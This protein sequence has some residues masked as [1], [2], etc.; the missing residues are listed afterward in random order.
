MFMTLLPHMFM[1]LFFAAVHVRDFVFCCRTCIPHM[2]SSWNLSSCN[3][4]RCVLSSWPS[5]SKNKSCSKNKLSWFEQFHFLCRAV[6][7]FKKVSSK[8]LSSYRNSK[9]WPFPHKN[10]QKNH[11]YFL[12]H[13][14]NPPASGASEQSELA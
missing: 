14:F 4:S 13:F 6:D 9:S 3:L 7:F 2:S 10:I 12:P 1:T 11:S 8:C 5:H